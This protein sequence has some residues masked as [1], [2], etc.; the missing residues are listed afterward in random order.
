MKITANEEYGLRIILRL[1]T[2]AETNDS[3]LVSL[4]QIS[5]SEGITPE[6]CASIITLLKHANLVISVRGKNGGYK[7]AKPP[8][9]INLYQIINAL[10]EKP[11]AFDFCET[12]SG[13]LETCMHSNNC[14]VRPVWNYITNV[15]DYFF[16]GVTLR[17]LMS[18]EQE[19]DSSMRKNLIEVLETLT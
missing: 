8:D 1:A 2:L 4:A 16:R 12:H 10:S 17:Q 11:F 6:Y 15:M 14:S 5:D 3:K 9:E 13:V 19:V 18:P 7:L